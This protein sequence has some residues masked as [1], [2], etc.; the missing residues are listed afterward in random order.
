MLSHELIG[1]SG[2]ARSGKDTA[3]QHLIDAAGFVQYSFARPI[4]DVFDE[5]HGWGHEQRE[6]KKKETVGQ[7]AFSRSRIYEI[8]E[9]MFGEYLEEKGIITMDL[10]EQWVEILKEKGA[11]ITTNEDK[12][13][14]IAVYSPR[15]AYQWF[16][17]ELM[18][19]N[20]A[21]E[22]WIDQA[23]IFCDK[24]LRVV[25]AD[26]RFDNEADFIHER[27]GLLIKIERPG[28]EGAVNAHKSEAGVDPKKVDAIVINDGT[29]EKFKA[30]VGWVYQSYSEQPIWENNI[31]VSEN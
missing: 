21:Q 22:F 19:N 12:G 10:A 11:L 8:M 31:K 23:R 13:R 9:D 29:L 5:L 28:V 7:F 15:Q 17:T 24:N 18:R 30:N 16:G 3:A 26:V 25:V 4:K 27:H 14:H 1:L 6:G 20:V 2:L